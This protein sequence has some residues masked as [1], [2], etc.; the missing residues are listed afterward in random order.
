MKNKVF[1]GLA[2][3]LAVAL[4]IIAVWG[5]N[6]DL[7]YRSY[8]LIDVRIGQDFNTSDI[9]KIAKEVFAK[10][11]IE[12]QKA[13][14]YQDNVVI[15]VNSKVS[16]EQKNALNS[17]INEKLGIDNDVEEM[18]V[19]YIPSYR[20]RDILKTYVGPLAIATLIVLVY[21]GIRFRKI[22]VVK[23]LTQVIGLSV[24]AEALFMAVIAI[25]RYPVNRLVMP[26]AILIYMI[27]ITVLTGF[28]EK[29]KSLQEK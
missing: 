29:Q 1:V 24:I 21:M 15:K 19:N 8:N 2:I 13:G 6:V 22:G 20:L 10:Q 9:E 28:F 17:K 18:E 25:T 4:V 16:D 23:V 27:L 5:F 14:V 26:S 12:V 3:V 11:N 7:S